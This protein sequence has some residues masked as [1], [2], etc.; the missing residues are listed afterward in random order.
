MFAVFVECVC[1]VLRLTLFDQ[2]VKSMT[3]TAIVVSG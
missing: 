1:K 2:L 3:L